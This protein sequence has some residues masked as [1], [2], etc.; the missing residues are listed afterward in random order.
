MNSFASTHS[1]ATFSNSILPSKVKSAA[2]I[3]QTAPTITMSHFHTPGAVDPSTYSEASS[4]TSSYQTTGT[5]S[6]VN[7]TSELKTLSLQTSNDQHRITT[8][9]SN[10]SSHDMIGIMNGKPPDMLFLPND[11]LPAKKKLID[12]RHGFK[13]WTSVVHF[14]QSLPDK[15]PDDVQ[16]QSFLN[17]IMLFYEDIYD[18]LTKCLLSHLMVG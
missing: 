16:M 11:F 7:F 14:N 17:K 1:K 18:N 2:V 3:Y 5:S 8:S 4:L 6:A 13:I 12:D 15:N 10:L 9:D